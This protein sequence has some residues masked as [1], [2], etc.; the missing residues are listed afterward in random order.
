MLGGFG[1]WI[2]N[3]GGPILTWGASPSVRGSFKGRP[4]RKAYECLLASKSTSPEIHDGHRELSS[5]EYS[6][7]IKDMK[8]KMKISIVVFSCL[9]TAKVAQ[10]A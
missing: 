5:N 3:A 10:D 2:V 8:K 9:L 4:P 6:R 1:F 7:P